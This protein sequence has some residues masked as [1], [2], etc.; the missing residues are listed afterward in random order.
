MKQRKFPK[1]DHAS[2]IPF[3]QFDDF[4]NHLRDLHIMSGIFLDYIIIY[5]YI[6]ICMGFLRMDNYGGILGS[7]VA[8]N[9]G[10]PFPS[11]ELSG[12]AIAITRVAPGSS[13]ALYRCPLNIAY[14]WRTQDVRQ[15]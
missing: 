14:G 12:P 4:L 7:M 1:S 8:T 3:H 13:L 9:S 15:A 11:F 6:Y 5:I 2:S 10:N